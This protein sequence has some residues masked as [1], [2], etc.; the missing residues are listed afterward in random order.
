M[1]TL[2]TMIDASTKN[3]R[4]EGLI[5]LDL[6]GTSSGTHWDSNWTHMM[7]DEACNVMYDQLLEYK[8][9]HGHGNTNVP[10]IQQSLKLGQWVCEQRRKY[11]SG[12]LDNKRVV[13]LEALAIIGIPMVIG[14]FVDRFL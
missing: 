12:K 8:N 13:K 10:Q 1:V 4:G 3:L 5:V 9:E 2:L 14:I 7:N 11:N 6:S